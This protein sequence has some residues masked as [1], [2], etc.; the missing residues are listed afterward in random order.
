MQQDYEQNIKPTEYN[1]RECD[2]SRYVPTLNE[3]GTAVIS[4]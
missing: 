3:I 2:I 1:I 4:R